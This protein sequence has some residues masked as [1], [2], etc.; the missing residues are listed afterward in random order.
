[1][2]VFQLK[3]KIDLSNKRNVWKRLSGEATERISKRMVVKSR[4]WRKTIRDSIQKSSGQYR[5]Y[6][7]PIKKRG[8]W[9]APPGLPP[10]THTG[11]LKRSIKVDKSMITAQGSR[12][13]FPIEQDSGEAHYGYFLEK[14]TRKMKARPFFFKPLLEDTK[15]ADFRRIQKDI[16]QEIVDDF[17]ATS[18]GWIDSRSH[19]KIF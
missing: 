13:V 11:A 15:S 18:L 4:E 3:V 5:L 19:K 17:Q 6:W 1:M 7:S 16:A 12:I 14:G 9:S 10:N 2:S 8:H